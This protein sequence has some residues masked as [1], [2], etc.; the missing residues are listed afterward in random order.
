MCGYKWSRAPPGSRV[1][2]CSGPGHVLTYQLGQGNAGVS[3]L[4]L[5][6]GPVLKPTFRSPDAFCVCRRT[7]GKAMQTPVPALRSAGS[8]EDIWSEGLYVC[9]CVCVCVCVWT[10]IREVLR[11]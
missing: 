8:K 3:G 1:L 9:V 2:H 7:P 5:L 11:A 6:V 10:L 4:F